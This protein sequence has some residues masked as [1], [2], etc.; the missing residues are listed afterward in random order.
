MN[1]T[2]SKP[3][4]NRSAELEKQ[5]AY[6]QSQQHSTG[7]L[8]AGAVA[9][10]NCKSAAPRHCTIQEKTDQLAH[11]LSVIEEKTNCVANRLLPNDNLCGELGRS[12]ECT[13]NVNDA[14]DSILSRSQRVNSTLDEILERL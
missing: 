4:N 5:L 10:I 7:G 12:S 11:A 14:L 6:L 13:P 3:S 1:M 2:D 9:G 8:T